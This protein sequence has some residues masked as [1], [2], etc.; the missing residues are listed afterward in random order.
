[1]RSKH[2]ARIGW[3][4]WNT[5]LG[6]RKIREIVGCDYNDVVRIAG[7]VRAKRRQNRQYRPIALFIAPRY[8][9]IRPN[10]AKRR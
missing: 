4:A 10:W 5:D 3:L 2:A 7:L 8:W 1:M 6:T 9:T